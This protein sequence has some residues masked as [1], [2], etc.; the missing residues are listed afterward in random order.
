MWRDPAVLDLFLDGFCSA[1]QL[2]AHP[3]LASLLASLQLLDSTT[4]QAF[5]SALGAQDGA[6]L[7]SAL[8]Y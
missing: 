6:A 5:C 2:R 7:S 4:D 8:T 3:G 1:P